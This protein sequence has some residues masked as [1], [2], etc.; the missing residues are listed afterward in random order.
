MK[1]SILDLYITIFPDLIFRRMCYLAI[2]LTAGYFISVFLEAFLLCR[3]IAYNWDKTVPG[4]HCADLNLAYLIAG[5]MN[6]LID[7]LVVALPMPM[8]WRL[9][10]PLSKKLGVTG[11]FSLGIMLETPIPLFAFEY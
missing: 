6:L 3:P 7:A 1:L 10:M 9:Q 11:M 4:G 2:T 5:I 8:L